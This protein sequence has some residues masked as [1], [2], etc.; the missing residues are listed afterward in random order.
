MDGSREILTLDCALS[1]YCLRYGHFRLY[2]RL[3]RRIVTLR[4]Q[5]IFSQIL[6]LTTSI[7]QVDEARM[8]FVKLMEYVCDTMMAYLVGIRTMLE[9]YSQDLKSRLR[10]AII[11][12]LR[13]DT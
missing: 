2:L 7:S 4:E 5:N 9:H 12:F 6:P 11:N 10:V 1:T 13:S 3:Y 8:M